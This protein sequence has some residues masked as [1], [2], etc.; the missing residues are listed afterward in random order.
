[1]LLVLFTARTAMGFQF[2]SLAAV[3][4]LL[5]PD[6]AIDLA[7]FG[8]LVGAWMLPGVAVALPGGWLASRYGDKPIVVAALV[9]MA[10]GSSLT[11]VATDFAVAAVGRIVSGTGAAVLNVL[12]AKMAA[13]W[14]VEGALATAMAA[15][16]ASWPIGIGL[17]LVILGP[18]SAVAS[19]PFALHAASA[20]CIAA[21]LLLALVYRVPSAYG[22]GK[23]QLASARLTGREFALASLSGAVW[24]FYNVAYILLVSFAPLLLGARG[25]AGVEAALVSSAATWPLVLSVPLGGLLADRSGRGAAILQFSLIGMALAIPMML[26]ASPLLALALVGAI[27]GPAAGVI[28]ALPARVLRPET[29]STGMGIFYTWY[30]VGMAMLPGIA[31]YA[32]EAS[33]L[34]AMPLYFASGLVV[35]AAGCALGFRAMTRG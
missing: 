31:G 34:Y 22:A 13:D 8:T 24:M 33:G 20:A 15:L 6:L 3:S 18:L 25:Y 26:Y 12:L 35:L 1:M 10:L 14:F 17:A 9:L 27:A 32:H 28:M 19:W 2:Q 29:R 11:A 7:L 30:Y 23:T 21:A 5:V 4:P 16:V